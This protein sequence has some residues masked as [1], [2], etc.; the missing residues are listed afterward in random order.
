[1]VV[2]LILSLERYALAL[3]TVFFFLGLSRLNILHPLHLLG[4]EDRH[5]LEY[6]LAI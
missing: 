5:S 6:P 1:M 2:L 4:L 3:D